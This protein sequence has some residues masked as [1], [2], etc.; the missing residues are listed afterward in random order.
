MIRQFVGV[1]LLF[2][3]IQSRA[4]DNMTIFLKS[5]GYGAVGGAVAGLATLAVSENPDGKMN[6]ITRGAS[7][8]LYF[9]IAYGLYRINSPQSESSSMDLAQI[10]VSP[11]FADNK[12]D[13]AI[14]NWQALNF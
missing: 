3:S 1:L 9:G 11:Y 4:S 7:L 14:M 2:V 13:G 6:N 10:W 12:V 8:G 5:C